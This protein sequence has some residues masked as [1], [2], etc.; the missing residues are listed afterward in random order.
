MQAALYLLPLLPAFTCWLLIKFSV[1]YVFKKVLPANKQQIIH[2]IAKV[3]AKEISESSFIQ[4]KLTSP[5]TLQRTLPIIDAHI[6]HFLK[7]KLKEALPVISIFVGEKVTNQLKE[8][9]LKEL[10]ELFPSVMSQFIGD[11]SQ[12]SKIETEI[13]GKLNSISI[14]SIEKS[15]YNNFAA[16]LKK[17]EFVFFM[18]GLAA[19]IVQLIVSIVLMR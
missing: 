17:T 3:A 13:V 15:F 8:L 5:E 18:S 4:E 10:E 1:R 6:D 14:E 16:E 19:G 12:S 11:L 2:A 9:F 7:V